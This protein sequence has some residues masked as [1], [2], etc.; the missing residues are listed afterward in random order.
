MYFCPM[1]DNVLVIHVKGQEERRRF[2]EKQLESLS[3]SLNPS[4]HYILEGNVEDLTPEILDHYFT[5]EMHGAY[6]RTSCAYKEFLAYQYILDHQLEGALILEDDIRLFRNFPALFIKSIEEYN[7]YYTSQPF[8]ANYEESS[9]LFVP[10]SKRKKG[11]ILY[12]A[13]RDRFTGCYYVS[14]MAAQNMMDFL[15]KN[16]CGVPLDRFHSKLIEAGVLKY[17]WSH[18][19]L[20]CQCSCDGSMPTMIP[21]RPRPLKRLKWFYKRFYKHLLYYFR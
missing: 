1:I 3:G 11:T 7:L 8:I 9:L 12:P 19:C 15:E 6:P 21:T 2:I 18:P 4:I 20:A 10:R 14:R 16:K 17:Y 13:T 5:G